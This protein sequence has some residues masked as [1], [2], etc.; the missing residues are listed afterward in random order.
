MLQDRQADRSLLLVNGRI[1]L[2]DQVVVGKALLIASERIVGIT[3]STSVDSTV[4]RLDVGGRFIAPGLIDIHTHGAMGREFNEATDD[5]FDAIVA[6]QARHGVTGLLAT[7]SSIP[8]AALTRCLDVC[9]QWMAASK[10][11]ARVLGAHLEGPYF[12]LLH[13]S[14]QDPENIRVP[15]DGT[16]PQLLANSDVIRIVTYAPEL[17]GAL[18]L[19]AQLAKI[20]I[21][22]AAGHSAATDEQVRAAM[23]KGLRHAVHLWS[24]QSTTVRVGPWRKPGLLEAALAFDE[25]TAEIIADNRHLPATLMKLAYRC[26]GPDNLCVV[27]DATSGAG[28]PEGTRLTTG[29]VECEVRDGV[30]MLLDQSAFAG[31]TTLLNGM[32]PILVDVVGISLPEAVRMASLTPAHVIGLDEDLGSLIPGKRADVAVFDEDFSVWRTMIGGC[33][34]YDAEATN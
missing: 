23:E 29:N 26:K 14:A 21:V 1:I 25:L 7:T 18:S 33:W 17:P 22:P 32:I 2:P 8:I 6:E 9:R 13:R 28:L 11:G 3:D 10:N 27:S 24:G 30:A 4:P 15:S 31:S 12:S 19:T 16:A 5:A 34:V 20:G